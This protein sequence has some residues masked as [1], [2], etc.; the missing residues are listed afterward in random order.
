MCFLAL[1]L[2]GEIQSTESSDVGAMAEKWYQTDPQITIW[3]RLIQ[4][5]PVQAVV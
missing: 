2:P 3:C 4:P 1:A 5:L